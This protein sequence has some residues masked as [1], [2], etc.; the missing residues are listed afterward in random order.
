MLFPLSMYDLKICRPKDIGLTYWLNPFPLS[1][2]TMLALTLGVVVFGHQTD[3]LTSWWW[4]AVG[5]VFSMVLY[6]M[7]TYTAFFGGIVLAVYTGSLWPLMAK[8]VVHFPPHKVVP[9]AMVVVVFYMVLSAWVVAYNF[10]PGGTVTRERTDVM[11]VMLVLCCGAASRTVGVVSKST[12]GDAC[13]EQRRP[14][15]LKKK[16]S[17]VNLL[18]RVIRRLSTVTEDK[19]G[20]GNEDEGGWGGSESSETHHTLSRQVSVAEDREVQLFHGRILRGD[21]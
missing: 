10:V 19:E 21:G 3:L 20:E 12:P 4:T 16:A 15:A 6:F 8:R 7:S 1:M 2:L 17:K 13:G 11:L 9:L 5:L 14:P 18:G